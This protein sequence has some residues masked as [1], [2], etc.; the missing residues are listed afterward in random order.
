MNV[1]NALLSC[2][3]FLQSTE[4]K[5]LKITFLKSIFVFYKLYGQEKN[6]S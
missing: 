2:S 5:N 3:V 4:G 1:R 6:K